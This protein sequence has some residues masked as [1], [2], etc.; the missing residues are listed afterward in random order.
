MC[1]WSAPAPST[2]NCRS[3]CWSRRGTGRLQGRWRAR[4]SCPPPACWPGPPPRCAR[5]STPLIVLGGGA[6]DACAQAV[7]LAELL[8]APVATSVSGKG[9]VPES[10]PLSLGAGVGLGP[11]QEAIEAADVLL[12]AGSELADSDLWEC[13]SIRAAPSSGSMWTCASCTRTCPP[14]SR[15]TVT[16]PRCSARWPTAWPMPGATRRGTPRR[17]P[18]REPGRRPG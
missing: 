8:G 1:G 14:T 12:V 16:P 10:H 15:S 18:G 11:V 13:G 4:R 2:W 5:A 3:T 7:R 17:Y 9:V 6:R